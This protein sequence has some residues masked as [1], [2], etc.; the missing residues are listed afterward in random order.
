MKENQIPI[1]VA[2]TIT[3]ILIG[4]SALVW[5]IQYIALICYIY[6]SDVCNL[7]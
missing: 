4:H 6:T 3:L 5:H 2:Y 1:A 7:F